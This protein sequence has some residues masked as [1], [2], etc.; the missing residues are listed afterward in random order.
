MPTD[1]RDSPQRWTENSAHH[2]ALPLESI[3]RHTPSQTTSR[4]LHLTQ[5]ELNQQNPESRTSTILKRLQR[6]VGNTQTD[7]AR[8]TWI[9][10]RY[11]EIPLYCRSPL[12]Y[13][14]LRS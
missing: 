6:E 13:F 12:W 3:A 10:V 7:V 5:L 11:S 4:D 9:C 8:L 1:A 2:G 14:D